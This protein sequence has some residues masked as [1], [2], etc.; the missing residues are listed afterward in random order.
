MKKREQKEQLL[1]QTEQKAKQVIVEKPSKEAVSKTQSTRHS[2]I[3]NGIKLSDKQEEL[4]MNGGYIFL[5]NMTSKNGKSRF[6][7]YIFLN[8]EKNQAFFSD[9][10][11][12][13]FVK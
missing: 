5:E 6:S 7:A 4:L 1:L 3:G 12:D 11:P 10:N 13:E 8:D 9:K 2:L